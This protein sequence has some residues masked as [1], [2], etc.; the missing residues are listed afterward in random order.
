[1]ERRGRRSEA[2]QARF[3][4]QRICVDFI[5]GKV[6]Q[7]GREPTEDEYRAIL[8]SGGFTRVVRTMSP[9]TVIEATPD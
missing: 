9:M 1:V 8:K 7:G 5:E 3:E 2:P 6:T 4:V